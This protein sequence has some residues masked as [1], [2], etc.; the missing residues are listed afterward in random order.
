MGD[1]LSTCALSGLSIEHGSVRVGLIFITSTR[2]N[3]VVTT[4]T[5]DERIR[6]VSPPLW[7][8]DD[9]FGRCRVQSPSGVVETMTLKHVHRMLGMGT[10]HPADSPDFLEL[11]EKMLQDDGI[12][13]RDQQGT[14][15]CL[16]YALVREDVW[17]EMVTLGREIAYKRDWG[18]GFDLALQ[19]PPDSE[20]ECYGILR[21]IRT[22]WWMPQLFMSM[23]VP[24]PPAHRAEILDSV[25]QTFFV[26]TAMSA[27]RMVLDPGCGTSQWSN[28][29]IRK[30][31][32]ERMIALC[33]PPRSRG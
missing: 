33:K 29:G 9:Y 1:F 8:E 30:T 6:M 10:V 16:G 3:S 21:G 28:H 23:R 14:D 15:G 5:H 26:Q 13:Y 17:R 22:D 4:V 27:L 12:P 18:A 31:Y 32:F 2:S 20:E 19:R 11:Q 7:G 24:V 25:V